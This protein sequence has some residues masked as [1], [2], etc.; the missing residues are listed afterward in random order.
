M[1]TET[2]ARS[3]MLREPEIMALRRR[4]LIAR[5]LA[6]R[7]AEASPT[8]DRHELLLQ[9]HRTYVAANW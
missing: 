7:Y 6:G 1:T 3:S 8:A 5:H 9:A 2:N 4:L